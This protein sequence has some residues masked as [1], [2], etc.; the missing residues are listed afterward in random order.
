MAETLKSLEK[1][2]K[3]NASFPFSE[4]AK[5]WKEQGKKIVGWTCINVPEEIIH[6]GGMMP[7]RISGWNHLTSSLT[8]FIRSAMSFIES[9]P[10]K[11]L[12]RH[13]TS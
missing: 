2:K 6:A 11:S 3:V 13:V 5:K 12:S 1:I 8:R 9:F 7:F 4:P 10:K